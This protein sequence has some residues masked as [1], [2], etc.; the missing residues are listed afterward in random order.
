MDQKGSLTSAIYVILFMLVVLGFSLWANQVNVV[1]TNVDVVR[2]SI[3]TMIQA[4]STVIAIVISLSLA[5][6][7]LATSTYSIRLFRSFGGNALTWIVVGWYVASIIFDFWLLANLVDKTEGFEAFITFSYLLGASTFLLLIPYFHNIMSILSPESI[8]KNLAKNIKISI[9]FGQSQFW[10]ENDPFQPIDDLICASITKF[11]YKTASA[12][13]EEMAKHV[14]IM[15]ESSNVNGFVRTGFG[16]ATMRDVIETIVDHYCRHMERLGKLFVKHDEDKLVLQTVNNL[17]HLGLELAKKEFRIDRYVL[18]ALESIGI[19]SAEN[20]MKEVAESTIGAMGDIAKAVPYKA[21]NISYGSTDPTAAHSFAHAI[22]R[23]GLKIVDTFG[24]YAIQPV[25]KALE[26]IG[27][28]FAENR[29]DLAT[30]SVARSFRLIAVAALYSDKHVGDI[31]DVLLNYYITHPLTAM[32]ELAHQ[33][34]LKNGFE[35]VAWGLW[36]VGMWAAMRKLPKTEITSAKALAKLAMLNE[37]LVNEGLEMLK[38][39]EGNLESEQYY[40]EFM[41]IYL[42]ELAN[43]L[44]NK[45]KRKRENS[46][47]SSD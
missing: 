26:G 18:P 2:D 47:H 17:R 10:Q 6:V 28:I 38:H 12:G 5:A 31:E 14:I 3:K 1:Y 46:I 32:G 37:R 8:I 41:Q 11:D 23:M 20:R 30:D 36:T 43:Q 9:G 7:Q 16:T 22:R 45:Q 21:T 24:F 25:A 42:K 39:R 33:N 13:L 19:T 40:Q 29:Y 27:L 44:K 34:G 15:V 35:E 4:Q